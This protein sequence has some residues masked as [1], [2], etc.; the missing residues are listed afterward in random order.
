MCN[1]K[2]IYQKASELAQIGKP[3]DIADYLK[4]DIE[5]IDF[6]KQKGVYAIIEGHKFI[7]LKKTLIPPWQNIIILHEI[8]H[9]QLHS[10]TFPYFL[11][12]NVFS[13]N[14]MEYEAN[15]FA[16]HVLL[17]DD[18]I[19]PYI[20]NGYSKKQIAGL[21]ETDENLVAIKAFDLVQR[22]YQIDCGIYDSMFLR[23][24][25]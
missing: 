21:T 7:F 5:N 25:K 23:N 13:S 3:K 11:D 14:S 22:G 15:L 10:Q 20:Y 16:A 19:L 2:Y 24:S 9:D 4:I 17:P 8:G 18:K 1:S 12:I 6:K